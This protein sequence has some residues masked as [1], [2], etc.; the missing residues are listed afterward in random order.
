MTETGW[1]AAVSHI[2]SVAVISG[3]AWRF[4]NYVAAFFIRPQAKPKADIITELSVPK[5]SNGDHAL[6]QVPYF[7]V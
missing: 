2:P 3:C 7:D 6:W 1:D 4:A 5:I